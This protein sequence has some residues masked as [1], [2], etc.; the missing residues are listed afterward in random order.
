MKGRATIASGHNG[1]SPRPPLVNEGQCVPGRG[2][3]DVDA[4]LWA[5]RGPHADARLRGD[6]R[7][8]DGGVRQKLGFVRPM[9]F[10]Q[11]SANLFTQSHRRADFLLRCTKLQQMG[12]GN[13]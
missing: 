12:A 9:R 6:A 4:C 13:G 3:M 8:C 7:G 5:P 10:L 11:R 2:I 1:S